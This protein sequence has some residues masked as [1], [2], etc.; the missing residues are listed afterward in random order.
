MGEEFIA[1]IMFGLIVGLLTYAAIRIICAIINRIFK[2]AESVPPEEFKRVDHEAKLL[3]QEIKQISEAKVEPSIRGRL[4]P[5]CTTYNPVCNQKC[6]KCGFDFLQDT[7][8]DPVTVNES[9]GRP[10]QKPNENN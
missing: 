1:V 6:G 7:N 3:D 10:E 2:L 8:T 5:E 9:L 4:C